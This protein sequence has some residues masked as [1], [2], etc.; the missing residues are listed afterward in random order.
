MA[1]IS[2]CMKKKYTYPF[3]FNGKAFCENDALGL[4][5]EEL[6]DKPLHEQLHSRGIRIIAVDNK[7]TAYGY[8]NT[9]FA[10]C[11]RKFFT[12]MRGLREQDFP[13]MRKNFMTALNLR[14]HKKN[15]RRYR[16]KAELC[17]TLGHEIAHTWQYETRD[18]PAN[19][20]KLIG[21][22]SVRMNHEG[23]EDFCNDFAE[24]WLKQDA[25]YRDA[26]ALLQQLRRH[27]EFVRV[28]QDKV[29]TF[30]S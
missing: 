22:L 14:K 21:R 1:T 16:Y 10:P 5:L 27:E 29:M 4:L 12:D 15:C 18:R 26:W 3:L 19:D 7:D 23:D 20:Q 13:R 30:T 8:L 6:K 24:A 11:G 2:F 17:E 28:F 9:L 25:N